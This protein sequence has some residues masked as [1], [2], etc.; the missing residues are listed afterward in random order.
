MMRILNKIVLKQMMENDDEFILFLLLQWKTWL[1]ELTSNGG[2]ESCEGNTALLLVRTVEICS[3][4]HCLANQNMKLSEY[5]QLEKL[6]YSICSKLG[7]RILSQVCACIITKLL[8]PFLNSTNSL[9]FFLKKH[10]RS[11]RMEQPRRT[12]RI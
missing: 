2:H 7:S 3:G 4:R 9:F 1:T 10:L 5:S 6:T 12:L 8:C 11:T